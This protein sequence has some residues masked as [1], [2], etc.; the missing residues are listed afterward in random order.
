MIWIR[1]FLNWL[2]FDSSIVYS[3]EI[4]SN[5]DYGYKS[6]LQSLNSSR[7]TCFVIMSL[8]MMMRERE[9]GRRI[10]QKYNR[11]ILKS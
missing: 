4:R 2:R 10:Y 6:I 1:F 11:K 9:R 3:G 8:L 5:L 7:K